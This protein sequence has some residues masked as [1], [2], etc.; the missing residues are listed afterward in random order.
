MVSIYHLTHPPVPSLPFPVI[1]DQLSLN[2][3]PSIK[4]YQEATAARLLL[5]HPQL[6]QSMLLP[7]INSYSKGNSSTSSAILIAAQTVLHLQP[8]T[9]QQQEQQQ[10][11]QEQQPNLQQQ[12]QQGCQQLNLQRQQ[13]VLLA[14]FIQALLPW[15]SHHNNGIRTFAQLVFWVVLDKHPLPDLTQAT[16]DTAPAAAGG[17]AGNAALPLPARSGVRAATASA[18]PRA[19]AAGCNS[20][21][22]SITT[23]STTS[24]SSSSI[25]GSSSSSSVWLSS[26]GVGGVALL[27]QMQRFMLEN[28]DVTRLRRAMGPGIRAWQA[29]GCNTPRR[30]FCAGVQLAGRVALRDRG[31]GG[32][33]FCAGVQLAGRVALRDRGFRGRVFCAGIQLAGRVA[34]RGFRVFWGRVFCAGVQ[35]A[36]RVAL[37]DRDF[38]GLG[39]HKRGYLRTKLGG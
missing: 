21:D 8:R 29:E 18:G 36:G 19:P 30:V 15:L 35:L 16:T 32:R 17:G 38:R 6:L 28:V 4:Q 25:P 5:R 3:P 22:S 24:S 12:Q 39:G 20:I 33:V 10:Q 14:A 26:F 27:S 37:K 9:W 34:L 13:E 31:F 2:T 23:S 7:F 11:E 1:L